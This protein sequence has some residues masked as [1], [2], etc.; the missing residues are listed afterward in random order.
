MIHRC[1]EEL[2]PDLHPGYSTCMDNDEK[3]TTLRIDSTGVSS[4]A[5]GTIYSDY[6]HV[7]QMAPRQSSQQHHHL[8]PSQLDLI[9][10]TERCPLKSSGI[11]QGCLLDYHHDAECPNNQQ[12]YSAAP[13]QHPVQ[14]TTPASLTLI[15][16]TGA[17]NQNNSVDHTTKSKCAFL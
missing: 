11:S 8:Q 12:A 9:E 7:W 4:A 16:S 10:S 5:L 6:S 3:T 1:T 14:H 17:V 15:D 2:H 13:V